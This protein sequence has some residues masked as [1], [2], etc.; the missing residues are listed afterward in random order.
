[1]MAYGQPLHC[2]DA[3]M[4]DGGE[5][6][7]KTLE[8]GTK[9]VTLDGEEHELSE[10]DL[11]ICNANAPM[12]IAGVLGGKGSGTYDTTQNVVFES[13]YFHPT[14]VRKSAR[15]HGLNTDASFRFERGI[16]PDGQIYALKAAALL[17]KELAGGEIS[18]EIVDVEQPSLVKQFNVQ[19]DYAYIDG[20]IGKHIE[21]ALVKSIVSSLEMEVVSET[22]EG[23]TLQIPAYRVDV[24]RPAMW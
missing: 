10:R 24:Q 4:I 2:F 7:V 6:V 23:L 21:P 15:R 14:W 13:A 11:A 3:D 8:N 16:D 9:F 22:E 1:M 19:V 18:M 5:I 12:C 20:V 17:A